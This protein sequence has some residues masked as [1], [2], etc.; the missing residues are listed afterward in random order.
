MQP[1]ARQHRVNIL[2]II[3]SLVNMWTYLFPPRGVG[4]TRKLD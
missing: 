1:Q 3:K 2:F 4:I